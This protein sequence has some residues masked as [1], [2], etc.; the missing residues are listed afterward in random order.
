MAG[1]TDGEF[2]KTNPIEFAET[3]PIP[4]SRGKGEGRR[5]N[6]SF[7]RPPNG[8]AVCF[9]RSVKRVSG[10]T[11]HAEATV[12]VIAVI[13]ILSPCEVPGFNMI[14]DKKMV[15]VWRDH[16]K[17]LEGWL[18][19]RSGNGIAVLRSRQGSLKLRGCGGV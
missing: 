7:A 3:N 12:G 15:P 9:H 4:T 2:A 19:H 1:Y 8:W 5:A 11:Q 17:C 16:F 14:A 10:L 6:S 18:S 13:K